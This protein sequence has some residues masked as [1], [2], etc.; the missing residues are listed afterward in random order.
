MQPEIEL[1]ENWTKCAEG[2][3]LLADILVTPE[4][5][6]TDRVPA[7]IPRW[8]P[9]TVRRF[10]LMPHLLYSIVQTV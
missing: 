4:A 6:F 2:T 3:L 7:A 8:F 10:L 5:D 1:N 9:D